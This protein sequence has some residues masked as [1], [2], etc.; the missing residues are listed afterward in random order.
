MRRIKQLHMRKWYFLNFFILSY[1]FLPTKATYPNIYLPIRLM[2][3][4]TKNQKH[5]H[6]LEIFWIWYY[7][8]VMNI[9]SAY[10]ILSVLKYKHYYNIFVGPFSANIGVFR[11]SKRGEGGTLIVFENQ[12]CKFFE[13]PFFYQS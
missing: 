5:H 7:E 1:S 6:I 10:S 8:F 12:V 2:K 4:R 11:N 13:H 9:L 3:K